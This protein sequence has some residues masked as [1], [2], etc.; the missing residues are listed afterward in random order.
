MPCLYPER[1]QLATYCS[2]RSTVL[3]VRQSV[4]TIP[5]TKREVRPFARA[6]RKF[7]R[8]VLQ[9]LVEHNMNASIRFGT[10]LFRVFYLPVVLLNN[11][12]LSRTPGS[13]SQ[14][15]LQYYYIM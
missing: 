3:L 14:L 12:L 11:A 10:N 2:A 7:V 5:G 1:E 15:V 6:V 13:K 8:I 4:R 9:Y